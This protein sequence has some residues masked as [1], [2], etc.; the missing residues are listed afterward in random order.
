MEE[1]SHFNLPRKCLMLIGVWPV[2]WIGLKLKLYTLYFY[3]QFIYFLISDVICQGSMISISGNQFL[4]IASNLNVTMVYMINIYRV[5]IC[6]SRLMVSILERAI[7]RELD[8]KKY[9]DTKTKQIYKEHVRSAWNTSF[10]YVA[11]GAAGTMLYIG[12]PLVK[13]FYLHESK[14]NN[15]YNN[16]NY[17]IYPSWFPFDINKHYFIAY[18]IEINGAFLGYSYICYVG[19]FILC[20]LKYCHCRIKILQHFFGNIAYYSEELAKRD[21]IELAEAANLFTKFCIQEHQEIIRYT[22]NIIIFLFIS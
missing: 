19:A 4:A 5:L 14:G 3:F 22:T 13:K 21:H 18:I 7:R 1:E 11:L 9:G 12:S 10:F 17:L 6:R 20:I 15:T 8:I 16:N 2:N